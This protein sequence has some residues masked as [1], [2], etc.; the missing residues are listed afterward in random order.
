MTR[1][2]IPPKDPIPDSTVSEIHA[3]Y[4]EGAGA[5]EPGPSLD[6]AILDAARADLRADN[7]AKQR[8]QL[9]WWKRWIPATTAIAVAVIGLSFTL[10]V[11]ELQESD[12]SAV[13]G[14]MEPKRD[15]AKIAA[16]KVPGKAT[17]SDR[18]AK[19][20]AASK[21]EPPAPTPSGPTGSW[22]SCA[23]T[24]NDGSACT[25]I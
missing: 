17:L 4:R 12:L 8:R 6:R 1:P 16:D 24:G 13:T 19:S 10:R 7:G 20:Q 14:A 18:P 23:S 22:R 11:S 2:I 3:L 15:D 21:A 25:R 9:P 5:A